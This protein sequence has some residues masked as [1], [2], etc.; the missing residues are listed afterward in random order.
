MSERHVMPDGNSELTSHERRVVLVLNAA[1]KETIRKGGK[2]PDLLVDPEVTILYLPNRDARLE[3]LRRNLE[4]QGM[5]ARGMYTQSPYDP[6][7][8]STAEDAVVNFSIQKYNILIQLAKLLGAKK[9]QLE[10]VRAE[11]SQSDMEGR[12]QGKFRLNLDLRARRSVK[13]QVKERLRAVC[14]FP[15]RA[16]DIGAAEL[17]LD[18]CRLNGDMQLRSLVELRRGD[19]AASMVNFSFSHSSSSN[20]VFDAAIRVSGALGKLNIAGAS[21]QVTRKW[22]RQISVDFETLLSF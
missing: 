14:S 9:V 13:R 2:W 7:V 18:R 19:N 17:L 11:S 3:Q 6:D 4:G 20:G 10:D 5:Y 1:D 21:A 8:Y 12:V 22:Q 16:P 15:G